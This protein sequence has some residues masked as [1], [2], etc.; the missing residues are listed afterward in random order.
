M[1]T[2][3]EL[4]PVYYAQQ[5]NGVLWSIIHVLKAFQPESITQ[6]KSKS[7]CY[8]RDGKIDICDTPCKNSLN[9]WCL[10]AFYDYFESDDGNVFNMGLKYE[11]IIEFA[12]T[13]VCESPFDEEMVDKFYIAPAKRNSDN[14]NTISDPFVERKD[15]L[16]WWWT[17]YAKVRSEV[18]DLCDNIGSELNWTLRFRGLLKDKILEAV[19]NLPYYMPER[20]H[21]FKKDCRRTFRNLCDDGGLNALSEHNKRTCRLAEPYLRRFFFDKTDLFTDS[22]IV[23]LLL[24]IVAVDTVFE[25]WTY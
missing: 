10:M 20:L 8:H 21:K 18:S 5:L 7:L 3:I 11:K 16:D 25:Y 6:L 17:E 12:D 14:F 19:Y 2:G 13:L 4:R 1:P 22:T 23:D 15:Y 9:D 24:Y